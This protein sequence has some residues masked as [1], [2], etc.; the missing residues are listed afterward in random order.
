M[1]RFRVYPKAGSSLYVRVVLFPS[2]KAMLEAISEERFAPAPS[3]AKDARPAATTREWSVWRVRADGTSKRHPCV[4]EI[5]L[6]TDR[7]G[8]SI[9][10][11]EAL[12]A[13]FAW[14]RRIGFDFGRLMIDPVNADEEALSYIH[15]NLVSGIVDR[16]YAIGAYE[17]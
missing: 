8:S 5:R 7:L 13:T 14:A 2:A 16:L 10:S 12:H 11:H 17:P 9:I 1:K 15:S 6:R 3:D 4:A